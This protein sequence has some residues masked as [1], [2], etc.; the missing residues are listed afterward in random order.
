M[1]KVTHSNNRTEKK[2]LFVEKLYEHTG[3]LI[4][5]RFK[6]KLYF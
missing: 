5:R 3:E 2:Q 4:S 1:K 6:L